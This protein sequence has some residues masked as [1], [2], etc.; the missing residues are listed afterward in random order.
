MTLGVG[1]HVRR[2]LEARDRQDLG[3]CTVCPRRVCLPL[4]SPGPGV[5]HTWC[6]IASSQAV[7]SEQVAVTAASRVAGYCRDE[8]TLA[9]RELSFEG[10]FDSTAEL[11][12][13]AIGTNAIEQLSVWHY[14]R[15][16]WLLLQQQ[17]HFEQQLQ[18]VHKTTTGPCTAVLHERVPPASKRLPIGITGVERALVLVERQI[19][20]NEGPLS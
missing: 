12:G 9:L 11:A 2:A 10:A 5:L 13:H 19:T 18:N 6:D 17:P 3:N 7:A 15:T 4:L 20:P 1:V 14:K 8:G 16:H